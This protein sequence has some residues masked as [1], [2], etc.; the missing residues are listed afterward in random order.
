MYN[1]LLRK[2]Y[3]SILVANPI[4][5]FSRYGK[6]LR[7]AGHRVRLA[8]H[9]KFRKF[10]RDNDLEFFPLGGDPAE[11]M[12]FMVK[13]SGIIPSISTVV[14]GSLF[15]RRRIFS[16]ILDSTWLACISDD[17]ETGAPFRAEAIIANPISY[18]H[19]HCAQK[20]GI[21][22]HMVFTMPSSPTAAFPHPLGNVNY[23]KA[24]R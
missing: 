20:L 15:R 17:D 1:H 16:D 6:A 7:A 4:F 2:Y 8:T 19:V 3:I 5:S 14:K 22:L 24:P 18:G 9:E 21:P 13:N 23:S 11:I 10:V 12:S